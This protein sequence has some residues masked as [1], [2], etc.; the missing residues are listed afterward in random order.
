[1]GTERTSFAF[2]AA[3]L[4]LLQAATAQNDI[5]TKAMRNVCLVYYQV[6]R[7]RSA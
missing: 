4:L 5:A 6:K 7:N 1:M 2:L 3:F